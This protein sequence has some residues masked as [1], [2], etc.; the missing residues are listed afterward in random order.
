M[1]CAARLRVFLNNDELHENLF[2]TSSRIYWSSPR[3]AWD[4]GSLL[5]RKHRIDIK[6]FHGLFLVL[7]MALPLAANARITREDLGLYIPYASALIGHL[8]ACSNAKD[9]VGPTATSPDDRSQRNTKG[10][11]ESGTRC[12]KAH[13]FFAWRHCRAPQGQKTVT[14][15]PNK[16]AARGRFLCNLTFFWWTLR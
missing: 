3:V 13:R 2:A 1:G 11:R 14:T 12:T 9:W 16:E 6:K 5:F 4:N 8:R 10:L 7:V 15:H